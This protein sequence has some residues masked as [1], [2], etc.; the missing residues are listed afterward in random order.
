MLN[1]IVIEE[2]SLFDDGPFC[3]NYRII[4]SLTTRRDESGNRRE[5]EDINAGIVDKPVYYKEK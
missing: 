4:S 5:Q 3:Y 1:M 2:L